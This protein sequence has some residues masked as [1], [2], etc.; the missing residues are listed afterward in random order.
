MLYNLHM[1]AWGFAVSLRNEGFW[2]ILMPRITPREMA[3]VSK[4]MFYSSIMIIWSLS[5]LRIPLYTNK[6]LYY[7]CGD[8]LICSGYM[9]SS[10]R[11]THIYR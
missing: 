2:G 1:G 10:G 11:H 5:G 6:Y 7:Y 4:L 8:F 3:P 9:R